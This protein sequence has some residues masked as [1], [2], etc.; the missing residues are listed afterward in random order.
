MNERK[1]AIM[2]DMEEVIDLHGDHILRLCILYL[3]SRPSAEDAFQETMLK[4]W[5][6]R[7]DFRGDCALDTW[8]TRIAVNVCRDMLRSRSFRFFRHT[9]SDEVLE[10]VPAPDLP[11]AEAGQDVQNAVAR[12]PRKYREVV[13]LFYYEEYTAAEIAEVLHIPRATVD[14]RLHRARILLKDLLK[15]EI[16]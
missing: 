9:L 14:T 6:H 3:G 12:L 7:S 5:T 13:I 16:S 2:P 1:P 10:S 11:S 8:L 4:A 15:E